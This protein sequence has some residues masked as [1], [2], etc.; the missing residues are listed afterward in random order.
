MREAL[1]KLINDTLVLEYELPH[2]EKKI[3]NTIYSTQNDQC[4][5]ISEDTDLADIIY[6]AIIECS[7]N[8]FE[9]EDADYQ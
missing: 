7:F 9:L 6:N 1:K 4:F 5:S 8:E 2:A 3:V